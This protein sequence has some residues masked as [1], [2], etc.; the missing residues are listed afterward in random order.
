MLSLC[1]I[2]DSIINR[3]HVVPLAY[4]KYGGVAQLRILQHIHKNGRRILIKQSLHLFNAKD[5]ERS[6]NIMHCKTLCIAF[7]L[8]YKNVS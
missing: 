1:I 4:L 3:G 6:V 5:I 7:K 8:A 2:G